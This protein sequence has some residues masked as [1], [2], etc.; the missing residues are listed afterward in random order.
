MLCDGWDE[1]DMGAERRRAQS[2][3]DP[4]NGM[5][6]RRQALLGDVPSG[7]CNEFAR[8]S[9]AALEHRRLKEKEAQVQAVLVG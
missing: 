9:R 6:A 4:L 8:R 1:N 2:E 5:K 3:Q 7:I